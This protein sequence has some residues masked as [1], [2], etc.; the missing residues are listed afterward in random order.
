MQ[1][2]T[3]DKSSELQQTLLSTSMEQWEVIA[4]QGWNQFKGELLK[5]QPE[6]T[7]FTAVDTMLLA[8]IAHQAS[9]EDFHGFHSEG[10]LPSIKLSNEEMERVKG[11]AVCGGLCVLGLIATAAMIVDFGSAVVRGFKSTQ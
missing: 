7:E 11:G 9:P 6:L 2:I 1:D 5:R 3:F 4:N 10:E 8:K